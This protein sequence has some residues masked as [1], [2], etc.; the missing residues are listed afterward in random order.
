MVITHPWTIGD[1]VKNILKGY[2]LHGNTQMGGVLWFMA[3]IMV[4]SIA[5]CVIDYFI[6]RVLRV[7]NTIK[8]QLIISIVIR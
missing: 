2:L 6:K 4:I 8:I 5:Y 1:I 3:M 7:N